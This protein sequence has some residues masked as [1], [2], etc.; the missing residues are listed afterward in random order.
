[1]RTRKFLKRDQLT[2]RSKRQA[3]MR[4]LPRLASDECDRSVKISAGLLLEKRR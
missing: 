1:M 3:P 4:I 2:K